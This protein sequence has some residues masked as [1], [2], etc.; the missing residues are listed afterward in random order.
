M[1]VQRQSPVV[2]ARELMWRGQRRWRKAR[3]LAELG[4]KVCPYQFRNVPYYQ[5]TAQDISPVAREYIVG[6]AEAVCQGRYPLL[7]YAP[8]EL[9]MPPRW[10]V[11]FVSGKTWA[12]SPSAD[13]TTVRHDGSDVKV[14]WELS[15]LQFLPVLAKA[16]LLTAETRYRQVAKDLMA[17]WIDENPV[18]MGVNWTI[19]MEAALRA[20]SMCFTLSILSPLQADERAWGDKVTRSLWE[21]LVFIEAQSEF[22]HIVRSNHYLSNIVGLYCLSVFLTGESAAKKRNYYRR[23]VEQEIL[24]QVYD[25]GGDHEA[26]TGYHVLVCQMFTT[27]LLLMRAERVAPSP[28]FRER[29]ERMYEFMFGLADESGQ[30]PAVGDCDDGR[31][32]L[33]L[34]D[35]KQMNTP[36][37]E[38]N[39]LRV[40][41]L[42]GIG[43][44]LFGKPMTDPADANWYG[45]RKDVVSYRPSSTLQTR[46]FQ[47]SGIGIAS[48]AGTEVMLLAIPNGIGGRGSH[49][50]NDKLSV[51]VRFETDEFLVDSGTGC[52][53][54]DAVKRNYFRSTAAH[55]TLMVD[56]EEQ[57]CIAPQ[58]NLL[59]CIGDN[60]AVSPIEVEHLSHLSKMHASHLGYSRLNVIHSRTVC[61]SKD[62]QQ[63]VVHDELTGEGLHQFEA[64]FHF[65]PSW[66]VLAADK[67][68]FRCEL[69]ERRV[70]TVSFESNVEL[71]VQPEDTLIS[72]T[73]GS[74]IPSTKLRLRS[75]K[76]PLPVSLVTRIQTKA[77]RPQI[78]KLNEN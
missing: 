47:N 70:V 67:Q 50:H 69:A 17:N 59:F 12:K 30:L 57:N 6:C 48:C 11:D 64:N 68:H 22:S 5:A 40:S 2:L 20:M 43:A 9:G 49:T 58:S 1:L 74:T 54:R 46:K 28:Q 73:F 27:A 65:A 55:N 16:Y 37:P 34:D 23:L 66:K 39:S 62:G 44:A 78:H 51:V 53:T 10:D 56:G 7:S 3:I 32:E 31:V 60:A 77:V 14:P 15:R 35:L 72:R 19:A 63:I 24:K 76:A 18:G 29:L 41:N 8:V 25:D 36:L 13:L 4:R 26:S 45:L 21:H 61:L 52:Y 71:D 42:L 38:R 33:L 75:S